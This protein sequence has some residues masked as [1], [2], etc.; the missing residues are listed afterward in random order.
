MTHHLVNG[1]KRYQEMNFLKVSI[2]VLRNLS[3]N[4]LKEKPSWMTTMVASKVHSYLIMTLGGLGQK[5]L[6]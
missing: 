1:V 2:A 6:M 5:Y 3:D 4:L